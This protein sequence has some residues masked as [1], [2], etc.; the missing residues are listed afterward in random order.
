MVAEAGEPGGDLQAA[1]ERAPIM[2][3]ESRAERRAT[4][5]N[6]RWLEFR[7]RSLAEELDLGWAEGVHPDDLHRIVELLLGY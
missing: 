1:A 7:G 3:W 2:L 5:F 6:R 4:W